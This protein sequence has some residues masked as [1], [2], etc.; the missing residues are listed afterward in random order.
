MG[1]WNIVSIRFHVENTLGVYDAY[2]YNIRF[3]RWHL[4]RVAAGYARLYGPH[5]GRPGGYPAVSSPASRFPPLPFL[6]VTVVFHVFFAWCLQII[7]CR[8][9][10]TTITSDGRRFF[11]IEA[12]VSDGRDRHSL[13]SRGLALRDEYSRNVARGWFR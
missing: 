2:T 1:K 3:A 10:P 8:H 4:S 11:R 13:P 7:T 9:V 12:V 6:H 5:D